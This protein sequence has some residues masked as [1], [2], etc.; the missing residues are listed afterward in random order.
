MHRNGSSYTRSP[1]STRSPSYTRDLKYTREPWYYH[2]RTWWT[3]PAATE[4]ALGDSPGELQSPPPATPTDAHTSSDLVLE[5]VIRS[6]RK[7]P[8]NYGIYG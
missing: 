8:N 2:D 3:Q 4:S 7:K 1:R 6:D 5:Q